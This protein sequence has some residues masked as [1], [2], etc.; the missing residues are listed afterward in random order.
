MTIQYAYVITGMGQIQ[1]VAVR[2][3][4]PAGQGYLL[5]GQGVFI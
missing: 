2:K 5:I 1:G 4:F 3:G